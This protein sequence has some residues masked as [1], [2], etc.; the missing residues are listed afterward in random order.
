MKNYNYFLWRL[1]NGHWRKIQ[2]LEGF[3]Y[4]CCAKFERILPV[5]FRP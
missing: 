1:I 3:N 2:A 5:G 4:A